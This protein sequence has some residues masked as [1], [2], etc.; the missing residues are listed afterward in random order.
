LKKIVYKK[1]KKKNDVITI[2]E[3]LIEKN[4]Q[5][6]EEDVAELLRQRYSL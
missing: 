1:K 3:K 5:K 6:E 4:L 2:K